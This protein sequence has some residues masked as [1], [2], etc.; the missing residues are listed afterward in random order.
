M[1]VGPDG[2][3]SRGDWHGAPQ[4]PLAAP[5]IAAGALLSQDAR[6]AVLHST[7]QPRRSLSLLA[8]FRLRCRLARRLL[9]RTMPAALRC[10][11]QSARRGGGSL[12]ELGRLGRRGSDAAHR[13]LTSRMARLLVERSRRAERPANE[14]PA[15]AAG[16]RESEV[17]NEVE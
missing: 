6:V 15:V 17:D 16:S 10:I 14:R 5:K 7:A 9:L 3:A 11:D 8:I 12:G 4:K 2:A 1:E 13:Q